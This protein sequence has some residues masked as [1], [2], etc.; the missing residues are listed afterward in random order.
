MTIGTTLLLVYYKFFEFL[1]SFVSI[2]SIWFLGIKMV[3][4]SQTLKN[5]N[6][7]HI[8]SKKGLKTT[9]K[10]NKLIGQKVSSFNFSTISMLFFAL[11]IEMIRCSFEG[12]NKQPISELKT[13]SNFNIKVIDSRFVH[14]L[15]NG[16]IWYVGFGCESENLDKGRSYVN[17]EIFISDCFFSR[18]SLFSDKGGV[19]YVDNFISSMNIYCSM[20]Y[21]CASSNRGGAICF[22]E[23]G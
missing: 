3:L 15:N 1:Q 17:V 7:H 18:Y 8:F 11:F 5:T 23:Q 20:F 6:N 12:L 10:Q 2:S 9:K 13:I 4:L 22:N 21:N 19:I 16:I 14:L